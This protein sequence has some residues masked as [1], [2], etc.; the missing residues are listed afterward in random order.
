MKFN[1][2][3][4]LAVL[5]AVIVVL[6]AI[7]GSFVVIPFVSVHAFWISIVGFLILLASVVLKGF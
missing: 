2:P 1:A 5:I 7:I 4:R 6:I 3:S